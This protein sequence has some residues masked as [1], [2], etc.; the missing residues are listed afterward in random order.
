MSRDRVIEKTKELM[1]AEDPRLQSK[2]YRVEISTVAK[3]ILVSKMINIANKI[4]MFQE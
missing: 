3:T 4:S 1:I 2:E